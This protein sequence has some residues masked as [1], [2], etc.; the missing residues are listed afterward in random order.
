MVG[1]QCGDSAICCSADLERA[2]HLIV[3]DHRSAQYFGKFARSVAAQRVHLPQSVLCG[4]EAL[5]EENVV[6]A[7]CC[8]RRNA[9]CIARDGDGLREA[10]D[11]Q[12]AI[13][14]RKGSTHRVAQARCEQKY[15]HAREDQQTG[16]EEK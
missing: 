7:G 2:L 5:R 3:R 10:G 14:L 16:K 6:D 12:C 13:E 1:R 11:F 9:L 15:A 4:H 8:D